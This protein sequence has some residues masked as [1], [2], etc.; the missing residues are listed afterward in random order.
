[1]R[2]PKID[3]V[4]FGLV[5]SLVIVTCIPLG[6]MPERAGSFVSSL[7]DSVSHDFGV[8]YQWAGIGA[9]LFSI[10]LA[11]GPYGH[12][13]LG[14]EGERPDFSTFSWAGM[15][16]C[17]GTGASLMVLAGVEWITY[18][19]HPPLGAEPRSMEAIQWATA[20]G[21]FHWGITAWCIYA[22]ATIAIAYPFY[23][24]RVPHLCASTGCHALLGP[25]GNRSLIGRAI[26]LLAMIAILGGAGTSIGVVAPT[27]ATA[28]ASLSGIETST[29]LEMGVTAFCVGIFALS[30][31]LGLEK[32]IKRLSDFNVVIAL[33]ML[34][35]ILAV[36]PTLFIAKVSTDTLGFMVEQF[37]RMMTWTDPVADTGFV[38][39]WSIFYWAW[40]FA[41]APV[42]GIFV[43][44][45]SRGRTIRQVVVNMVFFGSFGCWI[46]YFVMGNYALF[47]QIEGI[48]PLTRILADQG[49]DA[50]TTAILLSLPF[51][52]AALFA[53][54]VICVVSVATTYDSASYTL[55]AAATV[56]LEANTNPSRW[57]RL[58][59]AL[60]VGVL[61]L[62][63]LWVGGLQ[64][65]RISALIASFPV[66]FMG[67]AMAVSLVKSLRSSKV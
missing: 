33:S 62:F 21:P 41:F 11:F 13:K 50:A 37:V 10:W 25:A 29:A 48:L 65:I 63:L 30:V 46:F 8:L 15:L 54:A 31:Y 16:F 32:G 4:I 64:I 58:F 3:R 18:Y 39:A 44:R 19:E 45:I 61:P 7:Y 56:E 14:G 52:K 66:L 40:W 1:M 9:I 57:H 53:F 27:V 42:I 36:G 67:I 28:V 26:D 35:Y 17:A 34:A 49:M 12:I 55:A 47:L 60:F 38:E 59:W 51:G 22:V 6:L 5:V 2:E 24:Q 43:S 23:V 20:Y